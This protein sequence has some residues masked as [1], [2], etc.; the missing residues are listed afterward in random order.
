[1]KLPVSQPDPNGKP[2]RFF[3]SVSYAEILDA[4]EENVCVLKRDLVVMPDGEGFIAE[5]EGKSLPP[6][7]GND[8]G[9]KS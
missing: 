4:I 9:N 5:N 2:S 3:G 1:M 7:G 6:D 8:E